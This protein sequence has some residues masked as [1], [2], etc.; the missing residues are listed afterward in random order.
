M[1]WTRVSVSTLPSWTSGVDLTRWFEQTAWWDGP[2]LARAPQLALAEVLEAVAGRF[3]GREL[4]FQVRGHTVRGHVDAVQVTG[5]PTPPPTVT[6]DPFGWF[7]DAT[8]VRDVVRRSREMFGIGG[9]VAGAPID[10]VEFDATD[11]HVDELLVGTVAVRIDGVRLEPTVPLPEVV[12]GSIHLDVHTTRAQVL[13]WLGRFFPEWDIRAH[14]V[15]SLI[16]RGPGWRFPLVVRATVDPRT[17]HTEAVG[18]VV[19]GRAVRLPR[20]LVRTRSFPVPAIDPDLDLEAVEIEGDDVTL[21]VRHAGVRQR[22][23]LDALRAAVRD[24]ATKLGA[25]IFG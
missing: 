21:R 20:F 4:T 2:T 10:A 16:V 7:A 13:R 3:T 24:G 25:T 15:D 11:V 19:L 12:S 23:H 8:R 9:R 14:G 6:D 17:V 22:L 5:R 1:W 18:V